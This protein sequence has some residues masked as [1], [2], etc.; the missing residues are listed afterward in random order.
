MMPLAFAPEGSLVRVIDI[1][2]GRGLTRRLI[3]M[4]LVPGSVIKVVKTM[5]PGPIVIE[6]KGVRLALGHG[7]SMK[8]LVELVEG[9]I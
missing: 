3:E 1:M 4:G 6:V 8:I 9:R 5:G 2:A 7:V